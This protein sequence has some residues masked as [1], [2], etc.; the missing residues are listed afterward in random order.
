MTLQQLRKESGFKQ[1]KLAEWLGI[2]RVQYRNIEIGIS[3][4]N[5]NKIEKLSEK[6]NVKPIEIIKA[7]EEGGK[8]RQA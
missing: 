5:S 8:H 3:R 6:F 1:C 7:W 2:S 4:I